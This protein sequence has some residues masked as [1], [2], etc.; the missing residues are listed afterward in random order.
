MSHSCWWS[1]VFF[2]NIILIYITIQLGISGFSCWRSVPWGP[3]RSQWWFGEPSLG[4][5]WIYHSTSWF[6]QCDLKKYLLKI[7]DSLGFHLE[8]YWRLSMSIIKIYVTTCHK[9]SGRYPLKQA[10]TSPKSKIDHQKMMGF[11]NSVTPFNK[12][13]YFWYVR[14]L[15][16]TSP[17]HQP[18][19]STTNQ[20][21][22]KARELGES[23]LQRAILG[24]GIGC[25]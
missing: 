9:F 18:P 2:F 3:I 4:A 15:G 11:G 24:G 7:A 22:F 14:F 13:G 16:C 25:H 8:K 19:P 5:N 21:L 17:P 20:Q 6:A 10:C 1:L 23:L 12:H